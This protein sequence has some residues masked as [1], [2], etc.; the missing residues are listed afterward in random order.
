MES[1]SRIPRERVD[2]AVME[3]KKIPD[4]RRAANNE[5]L[6]NLSKFKVRAG[7]D[8]FVLGYPL[9]IS[10]GAKFP[11]WKRASIASEP[12]ID[13]DSLP[14]IV[15]DTATREGILV[16]LYTCETPDGGFPKERAV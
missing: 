12:D 3:F 15:I 1:A 13:V 16:R 6:L 14:K 10:G 8:A 11:I 4:S 2:I 7:M 5:K 9:G